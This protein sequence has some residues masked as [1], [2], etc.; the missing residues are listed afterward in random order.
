HQY[1]REQHRRPL[2]LVFEI[3][4][5]VRVTS[6][7]TGEERP[8]H[9]DGRDVFLK[10]PFTQFLLPVSSYGALTGGDIVTLRRIPPAHVRSQQA[11]VCAGP[12]EKR[13]E[14]RRP[15]HDIDDGYPPTAWLPLNPSDVEAETG[16]RIEQS[17][18]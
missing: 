3:V 1:W 8:E 18:R 7:K 12:K 5:V 14:N 15:H 9:G 6:F 10:P 4:L 11:E 16:D 17:D 13:R 2:N